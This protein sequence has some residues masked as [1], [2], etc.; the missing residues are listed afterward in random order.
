MIVT[1]WWLVYNS[2]T[3]TQMIYTLFHKAGFAEEPRKQKTLEKLN[4]K[5]LDE[6]IC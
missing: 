6:I 3:S 5:K 4:W 2:E 1:S